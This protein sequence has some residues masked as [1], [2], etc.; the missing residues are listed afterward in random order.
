YRLVALPE[1]KDPITELMNE[2]LGTQTRKSLMKELGEDY[3]YYEYLKD[4]REIKG[5]Q[6]RLPF[7]M[8]L[9]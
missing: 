8:V 4:L 7:E 6:A 3:R 2:F 5:I 9:E 1:K